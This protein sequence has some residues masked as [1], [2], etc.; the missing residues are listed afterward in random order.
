MNPQSLLSEISVAVIGYPVKA[1]M[2]K[3]FVWVQFQRDG[4]FH[5][6]EDMVE[7]ALHPDAGS[8]KQKEVEP[9]LQL[10][11]GFTF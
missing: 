3:M 6:E 11:G 5:D 9:G 4:F 8:R 2:D 1:S 7:G 10:L